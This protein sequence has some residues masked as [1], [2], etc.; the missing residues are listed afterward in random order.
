MNYLQPDRLNALTERYVLGTMNWR[1]RR[2]FRRVLEE[3]QDANVLMLRWEES[4]S[5]LR[6]SIP[7]VQPSE[8]VWR[9]ILKALR[10]VREPSRM[11]PAWL[12]V[13]ASLFMALLI[14]SI[15]W[16]QTWLQSPTTT[17]IVSNNEGQDLW[18]ASYSKRK[19]ELDV[20]VNQAPE[21]APDNDYQLWVLDEGVPR[22]LG[23]LPK[24]GRRSLELTA[25]AAAALRDGVTLAVSLEPLGGSPELVPTGPV[26]YTTTLY[27][28]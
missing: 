27:L 2:R 11:T 4:L 3:H 9:R 15:G 6:R 1:A 5:D 8:L 22:S 7:E 12:G 10:P 25:D 26:L 20:A 28:P 17:T 13:V 23:L 19:G 16:W 24:S 21:L 18:I 14:T